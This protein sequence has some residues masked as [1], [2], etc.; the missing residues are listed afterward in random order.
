MNK[1]QN[2]QTWKENNILTKTTSKPITQVVLEERYS[3][4]EKKEKEIKKKIF[5]HELE[6]I[7]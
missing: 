5:Y 1:N 4:Q 7:W 6:Q 2:Q 3:L